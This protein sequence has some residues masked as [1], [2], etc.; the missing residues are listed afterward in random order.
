MRSRET[1]RLEYCSE[2]LGDQHDRGPSA[3]PL[4]LSGPTAMSLLG[5]GYFITRTAGE[6]LHLINPHAASE[7]Q[8]WNCFAGA[9][10]EATRLALSGN[11]LRPDSSRQILHT[12][13]QLDLVCHRRLPKAMTSSS[14][15]TSAAS[16]KNGATSR[17][18]ASS[19]RGPLHPANRARSLFRP[20]PMSEVL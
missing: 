9:A 19:P 7:R 5:P 20:A 2:A 16:K 14:S 4:G 13:F 18:I 1:A 17:Y 8:M 15:A 11:H 3:R 6:L 12:R 10:A